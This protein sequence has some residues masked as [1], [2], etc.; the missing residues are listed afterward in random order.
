MATGQS[1]ALSAPV[2]YRD[3]PGFPGYRVGDDGS[4]WS[5]R[6]RLR[7]RG[8]RGGG[9]GITGKWQKLSQHLTRQGHLRAT[10]YRNAKPIAVGVHRLVL[11]SFVGPCPDGLE[12]CHND[13][14]PRNNRPDNLR[15]DT[16]LANAADKIRHGRD[17]RGEKCVTAVLTADQVRAIRAEYIP[18]KFGLSRLADKYGITKTAI[19]RILSRRS[20]AYLDAPE[21]KAGTPDES[22]E[23]QTP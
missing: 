2:E 8:I 10:L 17:C 1:T 5:C 15:W 18:G 16:S 6:G 3:I 21:T 23:N 4:V 22:Q 14:N 7:Q 20:W 11:L 12:G 19:S 13:G 9:Y